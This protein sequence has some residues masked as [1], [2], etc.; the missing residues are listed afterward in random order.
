MNEMSLGGQGK[1]EKGKAPTS[2][3]SEVERVREVREPA[4]T[5]EGA[6]PV[7]DMQTSP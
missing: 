4:Y 6:G 3:R 5:D 1:G 7:P 2:Y